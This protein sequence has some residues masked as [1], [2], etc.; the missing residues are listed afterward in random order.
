LTG[1]RLRE[2]VAGTPPQCFFGVLVKF[3]SQV[4]QDRFLLENFFR[5]RRGGVFLDIGAYDGETFS[6]T[7]FF[8]RSMG[9]TGLCVEPLP[10][11][12]A[13]LAATRKAICENICLGDFEGE[14]DFI[15]A[16]DLGGPNEQMFSGL[17]ANFDPR[18]IIRVEAMTKRRVTRRVKVTK[19]S[20]LLAKHSLFDID[21]C[22]LDVEGAELA[23]L[24]DFDP[25]RF[26]VA[27]FA[28]ENNWDDA[29]IPQLMAQKGYELY[30]K[31][32]Q[33]YVFKRRDVKPL[34]RT[35]I[36]CAVWHGDKDRHTRLRGHVENLAR[37]TAP[38]DAVY[39]F[40]GGDAPPDW[41]TARAISVKEPLTIY[42]AWNVALS[43]VET[44]LAMNLNLDDRLAPDAVEMLELELL[45]NR[46]IAAGGEWK[47]C[48]SQSETDSVR[49]CYPARDLPFVA[50][51]PPQPGTLTRLGSGTGERGTLGPATIWRMEAH[52]GAP[53]YPWRLREGSLLKANGDLAWWQMLQSNPNFRVLAIPMVIGNY[54]SHPAEQAEFRYA[55]ERALMADPGISLT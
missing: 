21:F 14:A 6:N 49:T 17:A 5:G 4:G 11:A 47:I 27:L 16:D 42:Q 35:S 45:K 43:L 29:R 32:E 10:S 9:W 34:A 33:D 12:F 55:D 20:T 8:E 23:I 15:E 54:H 51:W 50:E 1:Q 2:Q 41:L 7:L 19:L 39:V 3:H 22:S 30:A 44:P 36:I 38:V 40:D 18:H 37:Q 26:R 31:L 24:S 48:Y 53:R 46:A 28:I 25:E 52:I 13:K